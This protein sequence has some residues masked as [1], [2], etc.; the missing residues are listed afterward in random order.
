MRQNFC[1]L[2]LSFIRLY[3]FVILTS[4]F[5]AIFYA[6]PPVYGLESSDAS[7]QTSTPTATAHQE[8]AVG[9]GDTLYIAVFNRGQEHLGGVVP[10]GPDGTISLPPPL[11][12]LNV[13]GLTIAEIQEL[14]TTRL[15]ETIINPKVTVSIR[16]FEGF[17]VHI[18][19][20]VREPLYYKIV[21]NTTLQEL[22]S[23]AGGTTELADLKQVTL[24][25]KDEDGQVREQKFDFSLFL[26]HNDLS[27]N[28]TLQENDVV[29][30]PRI[31][32]E[33]RAKQV[34]TVLGSVASPGIHELETASPLLYVL[35]LA[36]G[37][38]QTSDLRK[39][40]LLEPN[41][42]NYA[43]RQI[44]LSDFLTGSDPNA[45]PV[46]APGAAIFVESTQLPQEPSFNINVVGQVRSPGSYRVPEN[47]RLLDV[48]F[49]AGGFSES[50]RMDEVNILH[51]APHSPRSVK[52]DATNYFT[53]GNIESNP[54]L[55]E[56]DT[57][58]VPLDEK[59]KR[60]SPIH[61]IFSPSMTIN[62]IG[63]VRQPGT[64]ELS[65]TASL[66]D[67]ITIAGGPT[68]D[69][70][71]EEVTVIREAEG[72]QQATVSRSP[73]DSRD[74]FAQPREQG[75]IEVDLEKVLTEGK[76]DLLP[77]LRSEDT[78]FIPKRKEDIGIWRQ[79]VRLAADLSTIGLAALILMGRR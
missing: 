52:V 75:R 41:S 76:F 34:V 73:P 19:G 65:Q 38:T 63:E 29:F 74:G 46:V 35:T 48:I 45:N 40:W 21:D 17:T 58:M 56:G 47:A 13:D 37:L 24:R 15:S 8:Y 7:P 50:S 64:Y 39:I 42:P 78:I 61:R 28:P 44:A 77:P 43:P 1:H 66:L 22:I 25:R 53:T 67:A 59:A 2:H 36:G 6:S 14:I 33:E 9:P 55:F 49:K 12:I 72:E 3:H 51:T 26:Q 30:I 16:A 32:R 68:G 60:I 69:A 4:I 18:F 79:I 11:G 20:Q 10:V 5:I 62:V 54:V 71:I 27:A 31:S 23:R 70:N 57:I